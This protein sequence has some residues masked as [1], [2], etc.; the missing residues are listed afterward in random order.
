MKIC[1]TKT[2]EN[3]C[4]IHLRSGELCLSYLL[5]V[6]FKKIFVSY[7]F[8]DKNQDDDLEILIC[9]RLF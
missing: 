9:D 2:L 5:A 7:V 8:P 3:D 4:S 1:A 6:I